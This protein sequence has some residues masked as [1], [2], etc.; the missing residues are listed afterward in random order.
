M[1]LAVSITASSLIALFF[2]GSW[3]L[4]RSIYK[5]QDLEDK[6][7]QVRHRIVVALVP[8]KMQMWG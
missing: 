7:V 5:D 2:V 8:E 6:A 4:T 1:L 3:F